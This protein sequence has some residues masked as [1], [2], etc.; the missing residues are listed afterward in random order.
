MARHAARRS[1]PERAGLHRGERCA[2]PARRGEA[3]GRTTS[4]DQAPAGIGGSSHSTRQ[5]A[6]A[7]CDCCP[8]NRARA[9]SRSARLS[10]I[11]AQD[12]QPDITVHLQKLLDHRRNAAGS[13]YLEL[14]YRPGETARQLLARYGAEYSALDPIPYY[15]L[16]VGSPQQIPYSVQYE[17][18]SNHAVGRIF[19]EQ[20]EQY[21]VY[22]SNVVSAE[23]DAFSRPPSALVFGPTHAGDL[24]TRTTLRDLLQPI[25]NPS[26]KKNR[27]GP[28][29][30][31]PCLWSSK[32][33]R[34]N[35]S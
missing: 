23:T 14:V 20:P 16:I 11:F 6:A 19:F 31:G 28:R 22:A 1:Q 24:A 30:T 13:R 21:A 35:Q 29:S 33:R 8:Q 26:S 5:R 34:Q 10:A 4:G 32:R 15:L 3:G 18:A 7:T 9:G 25:A 12:L 2:S 17:L 27:V